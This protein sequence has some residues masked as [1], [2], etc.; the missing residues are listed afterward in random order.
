MTHRSTHPVHRTP[1]LLLAL[2][3]ALAAPLSGR[4]QERMAVPGWQAVFTDP[5]EYGIAA[6]PLR[7]TGGAG[8]MGVG[9]AS[10][11]PSPR[12]SALLLQS[13]KA[14]DYRGRRIRFS[15]WLRTDEVNGQAGLFARVDG[16]GVV[17]TSDYM[18]GRTIDGNTRWTQYAVV[19]DVPRDAIGITFGLQLTGP[20]EL[21][22]DDASFE[23][24]DVSVAV[25]GAAGYVISPR[26]AN[27]NGPGS[28]H[29]N[30]SG[31][32]V[33]QAGA[34]A[35]ETSAKRLAQEKAYLHAPLQPVN[36]DFERVST[37]AS[38]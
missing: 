25:T 29:G 30:G 9:I 24:V 12:G 32:G 5:G 38:R 27:G 17:Q 36:L 18:L 33:V 11:M 1:T 15:A 26:L 13:I 8:L 23:A 19:L 31:N 35:G 2:G 20:G 10:T 28:G 14:D 6:E 7:R 4:A 22:A 16:G 34:I 3:V 37:I 21:F